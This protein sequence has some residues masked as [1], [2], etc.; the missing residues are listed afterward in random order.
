[1]N[2]SKLNDLQ[3]N[4]AHLESMILVYSA[5]DFNRVMD[6]QAELNTVNLEI[7]DIITLNNESW[8]KEQM[9]RVEA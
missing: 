1:M 6:L 3:V 4:A 8:L 9:I 2:H 7:L 5:I